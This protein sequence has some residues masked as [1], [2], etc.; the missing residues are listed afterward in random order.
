MPNQFK[1]KSKWFSRIITVYFFGTEKNQV[2]VLGDYQLCHVD[3]VQIGQLWCLEYYLFNTR[4]NVKT[5]QMI[6]WIAI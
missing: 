3:F 1:M 4:D 6:E 2:R 5:K